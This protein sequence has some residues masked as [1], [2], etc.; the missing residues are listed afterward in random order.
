MADLAAEDPEYEYKIPED[1]RQQYQRSDQHEQLASRRRRGVPDRKRRRHQI[2][3]YRDHDAEVAEQEQ[4]DRRE[5]R[6]YL[7]SGLEPAPEREGGDGGQQRHRP[8][9]VDVRRREPACG[10]ALELERRPQ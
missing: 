4:R 9:I 5:E 10:D 2:R 8:Q 1:D 7:A 3:K 6:R